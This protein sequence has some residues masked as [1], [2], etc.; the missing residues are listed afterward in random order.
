MP[1]PQTTLPGLLRRA[2]PEIGQFFRG[3]HA[4][5]GVVTLTNP[6]A[7]TMSRDQIGNRMKAYEE[8]AR[9]TLPRRLPVIIRV[10]GKAFHTWTKG[11]ARPF[12]PMLVEILNEVGVALCE[13]VQGA[14]LAYLQSD[15]I[16]ILVHGYKSIDTQPWFSNEVQKMVSIS[17]AIASTAATV[18]S[19]RLFGTTKTALF[20][21]RVFVLPENDVCNYFLWRQQDATRNS[22]SML[23]QAHFSPKQCHGKNRRELIAMLIAEKGIDWNDSPTT[24]KRGRCIRKVTFEKDGGIRSRWDVDNEIPVF[25]ENR[26]YV[27]DLLA[28][29]EDEDLDD[30]V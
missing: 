14:S 18:A 22:V 8:A 11:C 4:R 13:E 5:L 20:D 24:Q 27:E 10:D 30:A 28:I 3:A 19:P 23:A 1:N 17:A 26:K 21:S 9:G 7:R 15:E 2:G 16:S 29:E 25:S 6:E 12:D